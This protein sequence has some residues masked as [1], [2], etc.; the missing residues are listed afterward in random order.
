M[1]V[2]YSTFDALTQ[3]FW[4]EKAVQDI[5]YRD[6]PTLK[7]MK[8]YQR[9]IGGVDIV[10]DI[11]Y[12]RLTGAWYETKDQ[13]DL[14]ESGEIATKAKLSW[15]KTYVPVS[16]WKADIEANQNDPRKIASYFDM[17]V[18]SAMATMK[19]KI[20][21]PAL[22]TPKTGKAMWS[23]ADAVNDST[24]YANIGIAD[25]P[26]WRS[27]ITEPDYD[28]VTAPIAPSLD[29]VKRMIRAIQ[30]ISGSKPDYIV[31]S[32]AVYDRLAEQLEA[33][34]Q[35]SAVR[36]NQVVNWGFDAIH[37]LSVPVTDDLYM[38]AALCDAFDEDGGDR[39]GC[40][41][42]QMFFLQPKNL[43]LMYQPGRNMSWDAEGWRSSL[44]YENYINKLYF[45][46]AVGCT[47]RRN[48]GRIFGIDPDMEVT[49]DDWV[50]KSPDLSPFLS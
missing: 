21:A 23:I 10:F 32:T 48:Q 45:W 41:G 13:L 40:K 14:T 42:H 37:V 20:L 22:W 30:N 3:E 44:D 24:P 9:A 18:R 8:K 11:E 31:T 26:Q 15:M 35:V 19:E 27:I 36:T 49:S 4:L 5:V 6:T 28:T 2:P 33:N 43:Q 39:D 25:V 47:N 46:G 34:D 29:N 1:A 7:Y 50:A 17:Y 16:L 38:E 12:A